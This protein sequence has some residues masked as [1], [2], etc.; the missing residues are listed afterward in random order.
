MAPQGHHSKHDYEGMK[1]V[2]FRKGHHFPNTQGHQF[3]TLFLWVK[4]RQHSW[5]R[6]NRVFYKNKSL[7]FH[8]LYGEGQ[9]ARVRKFW[10]KKFEMFGPMVNCG[11]KH[12]MELQPFVLTKHPKVQ[13]YKNWKLTI[14]EI[15]HLKENSSSLV[16]AVY[17]MFQ[18]LRN[19]SRT[20]KLS[21]NW[22]KLRY[23]L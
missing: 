14:A 1:M 19:N 11:E 9:D 3:S 6:C 10:Y 12:K 18:I 23:L 20:M 7:E 4:H 2:H 8:L 22:I 5:R 15:L 16:F 13:A 17:H 21:M